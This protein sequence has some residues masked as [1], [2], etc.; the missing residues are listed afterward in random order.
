MVERVWVEPSVHRAWAI[1]RAV[2][3]S[4]GRDACVEGLRTRR[5]CFVSIMFRPMKPMPAGDP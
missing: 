2:P 1:G 4:C 5:F 3:L